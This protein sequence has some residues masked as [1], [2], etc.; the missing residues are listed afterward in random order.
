MYCFNYLCKT[1]YFVRILYYILLYYRQY[2][3]LETLATIFCTIL[4]INTNNII[5]YY[6]LDTL[7]FCLITR[8]I[9]CGII[10]LTANR[11]KDEKERVIFDNNNNIAASVATI[12]GSLIAMILKLD[13]NIMLIIATIGNAI[14]NIFYIVIYTKQK[15]KNDKLHFN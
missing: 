8:N 15:R 3:V 6:I 1:F 13:F 11:Y 4:C 5:V 9:I 7:F 10:K 2:C 12:I 14:D